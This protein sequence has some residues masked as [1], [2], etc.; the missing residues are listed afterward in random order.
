M[1]FFIFNKIIS[2][3]SF[4]ITR[5]KLSTLVVLTYHSVTTQ[6]TKNFAD[7]M[8]ILLKIGKPVCLEKPISEYDKTN[9]LAVTF[10][11]GYQSVIHNALPIL[12]QNRIPATIFIPSNAFGKQPPWIRDSAHPFARETVLTEEQLKTLPDDLITIGS[13]TDSHCRLS[14]IDT[15]TF[16]KEINDSKR[17]LESLLGREISL[18]S[19]PY[20]QFDKKHT[21]LFKE[22]GYQRV[23]L[24]IPTFPATN[25]DLF[26]MGRISV[27][28]DDWTLEYRLKL[29]GAYQWLPFAIR[30]KNKLLSLN[31]LRS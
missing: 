30:M 24:N 29:K 28:P 3:L 5:R 11:D 1:F 9:Y 8:N 23:F 15:F 12:K 20:G 4:V 7:Q 14:N 25:T 27:E 10:D 31:V 22:A 18:I 17:K 2:Y 6:Q 16:K 13:H 21:K 26:V 19:V